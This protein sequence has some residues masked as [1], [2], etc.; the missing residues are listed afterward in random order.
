MRRKPNNPLNERKTAMSNEKTYP[1]FYRGHYLH[2][3]A[4]DLT[5][6]E[7][8][9][10][11]EWPMSKILDEINRDR[12]EGWT[13]YDETD[14]QEGLDEWTCYHPI[15]QEWE[16]HELV[17]EYDR[18]GKW[19]LIET[20]GEQYGD[21][22]YWKETPFAVRSSSGED[23]DRYATLDAAFRDFARIEELYKRG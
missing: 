13:A 23:W 3:G 6:P 4:P 17:K 20:V 10:V 19:R 2:D 9:K 5:D 22:G 21:D 12:S 11:Q 8:G 1:I 7:V 14:W 15:T 18:L 16:G